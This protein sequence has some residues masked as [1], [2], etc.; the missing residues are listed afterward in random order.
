M[1]EATNCEGRAGGAQSIGTIL[2]AVLTTSPGQSGAQRFDR[3]RRSRNQLRYETRSVGEADADVA[4]RAD[5]ALY[6][7]AIARD[8][9]R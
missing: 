4:S 6:E 3:M 1:T 5:R 7:G 8:V 2:K 9:G